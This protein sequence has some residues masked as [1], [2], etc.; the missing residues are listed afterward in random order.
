MTADIV[1]S[2]L[3]LH[4]KST[5]SMSSRILRRSDNDEI[6]E[7]MIFNLAFWFPHIYVRSWEL[8]DKA[9]IDIG[10]CLQYVRLL[11]PCQAG[12]MLTEEIANLLTVRKCADIP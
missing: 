4:L 5:Q 7:A 8:S 10:H 9:P 6:T 11:I 1:C 12:A 3:V 2:E